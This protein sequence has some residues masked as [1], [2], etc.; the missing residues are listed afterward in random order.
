MSKLVEDL[1]EKSGPSLSCY[2]STFDV[3]P[4][5][6]FNEIIVVDAKQGVMISLIFAFC[7][8]FATTQNIIVSLLATY[9]ISAII[10]QMMA[11][12]KFN[13]WTFGIIQSICVIVFIGMAVDYVAH[14]AHQYVHSTHQIKR[15][16]TN[17][18]YR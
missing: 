1:N 5:V 2:L 18:A 14:I 12:I 7:V 10:L 16:R 6:Y 15:N 17:E 8:L 4:W 3:F 11:M 9:S 13:N